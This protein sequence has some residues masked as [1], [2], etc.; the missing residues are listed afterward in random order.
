MCVILHG[1]C[2]WIIINPQAFRFPYVRTSVAFNPGLRLAGR[3]LS[4][5]DTEVPGQAR[6]MTASGL[7]QVRSLPP[8]P[9]GSGRAGTRKGSLR[10]LGRGRVIDIPT[11]EQT[12]A[13]RGQP[14]PAG[15]QAPIH[16]PSTLALLQ[17]AT[18]HPCCWFCRV[19]PNSKLKRALDDASLNK[20][21][22][23]LHWA[24]FLIH[25]SKLWLANYCQKR[26]SWLRLSRKS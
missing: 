15:Q 23:V 7:E 6:S 20:I 22:F 14:E 18:P 16:C 26:G 8:T 5:V 10:M 4:H 3:A 2:L 11:A 21:R 25:L 19:R 24:H 9:A 13:H 1:F 17:N 12:P